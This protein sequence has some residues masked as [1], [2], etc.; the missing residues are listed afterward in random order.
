MIELKEIELY[1]TSIIQKACQDAMINSKMV[2]VVDYSGAG[3]TFALEKFVRENRGVY[4]IELGPSMTP[5]GMYI[6]ILNELRGEDVN[7]NETTSSIIRQIRIELKEFTGNRLIIIDEAGRYEKE[8]VVYFHELRN[9][10]Q[11]KCGLIISAHKH[12]EQYLAKW[13]SDGIPGVD[14]FSNRFSYFISLNRPSDS[15][16]KLYFEAN[17]LLKTKEQISLFNE[18]IAIKKEKRNWRSIYHMVVGLL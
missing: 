12:F 13:V 8:R 10:S 6:Q 5:K 16:V 14:E 17:G 7:R 1:N 9:L 15:E 18:I 11:N 3:K 4:K 2:G